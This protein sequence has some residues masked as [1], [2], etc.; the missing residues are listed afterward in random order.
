MF[1]VAKRSTDHHAIDVVIANAGITGTDPV[2][3][4]QGKA[5][6][7]ICGGRFLQSSQL[8]NQLALQDQN[9]PMKPD[10]KIMDVNCTGAIY[11]MTL[12]R[13]YFLKNEPG[14]DR[15]FIIFSSLAGY[16]DVPGGPLYMASKFA[17]RAFMRCLRRTTVVDGIRSC[18]IA[19]WYVHQFH[20]ASA[21]SSSDKPLI[22]IG[23]FARVS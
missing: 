4:G 22:T 12:A 10:L 16:V 6:P 5:N 20:S 8:T 21:H 14:R 3:Y 13:H 7:S 18:A 11:T 15:C 9:E 1:K 17:A 2:F 19:P 23:M